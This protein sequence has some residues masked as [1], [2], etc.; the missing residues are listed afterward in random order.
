M[1]K[2]ALTRDEACYRILKDG[3]W[4]RASTLVTKVSHRFGASIFNLREAGCDII[5]EYSEKLGEWRYKMYYDAI[6]GEAF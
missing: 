3:K 5:S 1:A 6:V 4:H 2:K